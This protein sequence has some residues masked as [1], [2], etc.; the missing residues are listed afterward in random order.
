LV[1]F[2]GD[3]VL[4]Q[5]RPGDNF[6]FIL[7]GDKKMH[8]GFLIEINEFSVI[9]SQDTIELKDV[10]KVLLPGKPV[11]NRV[12]QTLILIG[13][14]YFTIDQFNNGIVHGNGFDTDADVWKPTAVL[15]GT[16]L[17]L[18]LFQKRWKK[19]GRGIK[20]ISVGR[21]SRFYVPGSN[22]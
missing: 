16:G 18:L 20:L 15:V 11:I 4:K 1:L 3:R 22:P 7:K 6:K 5:F 19:L 12:G 21:D 14:A 13:V 10:K 17:P 2:H 8:W 9:T